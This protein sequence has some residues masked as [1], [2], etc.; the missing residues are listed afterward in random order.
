MHDQPTGLCRHLI[1]AGD[2][3]LPDRRAAGHRGGMVD[4]I[5]F[6]GSLFAQQPFHDSLR[7][8]FGLG[9]F[10]YRF[11]FGINDL[12]IKIRQ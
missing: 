7:Q 12:H 2:I 8:F 9:G 4:N 3:F 11:S 1:D 10:Q 5:A 6:N